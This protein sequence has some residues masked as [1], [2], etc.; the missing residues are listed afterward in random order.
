MERTRFELKKTNSL[1][2]IEREERSKLE[3]ILEKEKSENEIVKNEL[4]EKIFDLENKLTLVLRKSNLDR[5][6]R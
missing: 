2:G 6:N 5:Q 1:L 3:I 4:N